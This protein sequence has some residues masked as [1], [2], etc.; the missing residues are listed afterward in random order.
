MHS[1]SIEQDMEGLQ[2]LMDKPDFQKEIVRINKYD[3]KMGKMFVIN[4]K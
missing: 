4:V 3:I 2:I 1:F